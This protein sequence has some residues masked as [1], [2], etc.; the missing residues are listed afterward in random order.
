M[1]TSSSDDLI[2]S[3]L[4]QRSD[5][6]R[7]A[8]LALIEEKKRESGGFLSDEGAARLVAQDLRV[9]LQS[10]NVPA[11]SLISLVPGLGD[12]SV[13]GRAL[14]SW[15][16]QTFQKKG[17]A[18][19]KV[20]RLLLADR[21]GAVTCVFWDSKAEKLEKNQIRGK[22]VKIIHGYT[23]QGLSGGVE[24]HCGDRAE[25]VV[26]PTGE[27]EEHY[28]TQDEIFGKINQISMGKPA[29][30]RAVTQSKARS[31]SFKRGELDGLVARAI[32][33]DDT[34]TVTLVAWDDKAKRLQELE[35]GRGLEIL[36]AKV[37]PNKWGTA[38]LHAD[39]KTELTILDLPLSIR[40]EKPREKLQV[41]D[42]PGKTGF[43]SLVCRL[44]KVGPPIEFLRAGGEKVPARRALLGDETGIVAATFWDDKMRLL[45]SLKEGD[46]ILIEDATVR[47][48][49]G[50]IAISVG[51][52]SVASVSP[53][54]ALGFPRETAIRELTVSEGLVI[55]VGKVV[56][57][58][59][60][61]ELDTIAG[62]RV[63][64][65]SFN[66]EDSTG[67]VRVSCW[68][69]LAEEAERLVPDT[70][71][72]IV[73]VR[74]R[75]GL[76]GELELSSTFLTTLEIQDAHGGAAT[77]AAEPIIRLKGKGHAAVKGLLLEV[78]EYS[79]EVFCPTCQ[80]PMNAKDRCSD[81]GSEPVLNAKLR[82]RLDD[83][84]GVILAQAH[85]DVAKKILSDVGRWE[86]A[87]KPDSLRDVSESLMGKQLRVQ[88]KLEHDEGKAI[89]LVDSFEWV[90]KS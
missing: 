90:D 34:G 78:H 40:S 85:G 16:V 31:F 55:V 30:V 9:E 33:A 69:N 76:G 29:H 50:A 8:V 63:S 66:L 47:A 39:Q 25:V 11:T 19:G 71:I 73:G 28:P 52:S 38:E 20:G 32:I 18:M 36:N 57:K 62:E 72:K 58:P 70:R 60:R 67:R 56:D 84:T 42:L 7:D 13:T 37:R 68:R 5:L 24:L 65:T 27:T 77:A 43:V 4:T 74:P 17:G 46:A 53:D 79:V 44:V 23:R 2:Q 64:L 83:G 10:R 6:T 51:R 41:K 88:G 54:T 89:M 82:F 35:P 26:S 45:D 86:A 22:L 48:R 14:M 1:A 61:R 49:Q 12:V 3:M 75:Q 80:R 21:S 15:P 81:C 59:T 87:L